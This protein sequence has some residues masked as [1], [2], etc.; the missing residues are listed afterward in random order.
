MGQGYGWS[1]VLRSFRVLIVLLTFGIAERRVPAPGL[2]VR[3]K[4]RRWSGHIVQEL[5][6]DSRRPV[7]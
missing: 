1:R 5:R 6:G 7:L 2:G 4:R 3:E